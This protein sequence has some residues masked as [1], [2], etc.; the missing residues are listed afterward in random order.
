MAYD[1][2]TTI[3]LSDEFEELLRRVSFDIDED[4]SKIIRACI[5]LGIDTIEA[6]PSLVHRLQIR[7]RKNKNT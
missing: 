7:D 3:K 6:N 2:T 1:I 5:L 4:K